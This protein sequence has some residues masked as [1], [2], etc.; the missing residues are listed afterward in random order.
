VLPRVEVVSI[1]LWVPCLCLKIIEDGQDLYVKHSKT[2]LPSQ[3]CY[4]ADIG[5]IYSKF[6]LVAARSNAC[7]CSHSLVGLSVS[8]ITGSWMSLFCLLCVVR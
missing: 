7:I 1:T 2:L 5:I 6:C 8:N 3:L 4:I